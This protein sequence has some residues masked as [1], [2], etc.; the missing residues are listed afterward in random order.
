MTRAAVSHR[1][2]II[3]IHLLVLESQPPHRIVNLLFT[4]I[5]IAMVYPMTRAAV[6]HVAKANSSARC[7][8]F[9]GRESVS[10]SNPS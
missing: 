8:A 3:L 6:S 2:L 9:V 7:V 5:I 1:Q 4:I 10:F